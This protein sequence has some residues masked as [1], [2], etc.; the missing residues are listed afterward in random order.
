VLKICLGVTKRGADGRLCIQQIEL[1]LI[2]NQ[3]A[4]ATHEESGVTYMATEVILQG[5]AN[6][7]GRANRPG[8]G[9]VVC[10]KRGAEPDLGTQDWGVDGNDGV[11][12][13]WPGKGSNRDLPNQPPH[14][15]LCTR[16]S[17]VSQTSV[18]KTGLLT[19]T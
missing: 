4:Q 17:G 3:F 16:T 12:E 15:L 8:P 2:P 13:T 19:G 6:P 9:V 18:L 11:F 1:L 5:L 14:S 10:G 7:R